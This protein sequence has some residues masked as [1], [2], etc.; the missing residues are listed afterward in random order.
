M[1][2]V[3]VPT[4]FADLWRPLLG[5]TGPVP[6]YVASLDEQSRD[7]LRLALGGCLPTAASGRLYLSAHAWAV[8]GRRP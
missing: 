3:I 4:V 8:R 5:A 7:R 6:G 2:D 1:R